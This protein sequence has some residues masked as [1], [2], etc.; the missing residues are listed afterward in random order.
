MIR[1]IAARGA[2]PIE[3]F[4]LER[5]VWSSLKSWGAERSVRGDAERSGRKR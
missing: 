4:V 2:V 1:S 3:R 5:R